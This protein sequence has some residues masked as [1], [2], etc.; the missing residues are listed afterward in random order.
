MSGPKAPPDQWRDT[1]LLP[2]PQPP[3]SINARDGR[4]YEGDQPLKVRTS[5]AG[6]AI[7]CTLVSWE[8]YEAIIRRVELLEG[9]PDGIR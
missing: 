7:G 1:C 4:L 5:E 8:A 2:S 3:R 9:R 6:I